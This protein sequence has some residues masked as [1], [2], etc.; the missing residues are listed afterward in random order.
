MMVIDHQQTR[1]EPWTRLLV[2]GSVG[3]LTALLVTEKIMLP[4][5]E[6]LTQF[7]HVSLPMRV[8][9]LAKVL[10]PLLSFFGAGGWVWTLLVAGEWV[11]SSWGTWVASNQTMRQRLI[12]FRTS[13]MPVIAFPQHMMRERREEHVRP[14]ATLPLF[15]LDP[16]NPMQWAQLPMTPPPHSLWQETQNTEQKEREMQKEDAKEKISSTPTEPILSLQGFANSSQERETHEQ[17]PTPH[18][19][20]TREHISLRHHAEP[21]EMIKPITL[22]LLKHVRVWVRADDGTTVEVKLRG[23]ENAISC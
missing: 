9:L 20:S 15:Q 4:A 16:T 13:A 5:L 23:G 17:K 14:I 8:A 10:S 22:T 12:R 19:E 6:G 21:V 18:P 2:P 11:R 3:L 7:P 1:M